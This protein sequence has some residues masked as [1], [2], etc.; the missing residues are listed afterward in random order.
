[1]PGA[2]QRRIVVVTGA[3]QTGKTTLAKKLYA[4]VRYVNLD[5]AEDRTALAGLRTAA[6]AR[7]VGAAV[8]D[9]AQKAPGIFEKLKYAYDAGDI[10]FSVLLGSSQI[11]LLRQIRESLAGRVFLY[12]LWPLMASELR[13]PEND[14]PGAPLVGRLLK[15]G[16][17]LGETLKQEPTVFLGAREDAH[18]SAIEHLARWG[19]MPGLLQL[20]ADDRKNW[21]RSYQ[22]TYL[23][24][25][26]RD[27]A[28]LDD[29][30]PFRKLQ[31]LAML[32][33][34]QLLTY[35]GLA[36][37]AQI[38]VS[39]AKRYMQYLELTY[40]ILLLRPF[41]ENLTSAAVKS[42]KAYWLDLG[43]LRETTMQFGP[44]TGA[45]FETLV[46]SEFFKWV[47]T[48]STDVRLSFYRT[49]SGM[50]LDLLVRVPMGFFGFEI[51]NRERVHR[52]DLRTLKVVADALGE[53]WLGGGVIHRGAALETLDTARD[54]WA[55]PVHRLF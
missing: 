39:T 19:G 13:T 20:E 18:H 47:R 45:M 14:T 31:E 32:R 36:R 43:L 49:R 23:E 53:R 48:Q 40:Q 46:V 7:T 27:L 12:E 44:M 37:D 30:A 42:P 21:L 25:D 4:K 16:S 11:L 17:K 26:L 55:I 2:E 52:K 10:D 5:A 41:S 29:L 51:K 28:R 9:E 22:H 1:M 38:S 15:A 33:T 35:S 54:L 8:L 34:G 6:W 3:R 50:E 24:R